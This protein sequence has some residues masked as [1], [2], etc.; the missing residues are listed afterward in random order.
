LE[1]LLLYV[2]GW[3]THSRY[4]PRFNKV[5]ESTSGH[6]GEHMETAD[7]G[8][9]REAVLIRIAREAKGISPETAAAQMPHKFSGSSWRQIEAGYRGRERKPVRG[10][11]STVAAMAH[12]VGLTADR[13]EEAGRADAAE[14][15][16]EIE[17]Q[18]TQQQGQVPET[19]SMAPPHVR[20]M[21]EAALEDVDPQDRPEVL[22]EM[23]AS[24]EAVMKR[25]ARNAEQTRRGRHAG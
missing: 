24:Y 12:T 3:C 25:R 21:I 19:L 5:R 14:I 7:P 4:L 2:K 13:L 11:P 17:R 1:L 18:E 6:E 10:R 23:A 9:P 8:P 15:L 20:R 22:R 16:R